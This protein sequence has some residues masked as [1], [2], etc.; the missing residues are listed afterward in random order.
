LERFEG[1]DRLCIFASMTAVTRVKPR[2][3]RFL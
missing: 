3:K 1:W 2:V